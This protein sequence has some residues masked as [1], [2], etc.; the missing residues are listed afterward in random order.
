MLVICVAE[1][2]NHRTIDLDERGRELARFQSFINPRGPIP[3]EARAVHRISKEGCRVA[4]S[5]FEAVLHILN[6]NDLPDRPHGRIAKARAGKP[7]PSLTFGQ[8]TTIKAPLVG[9]LSRL[10]MT[11]I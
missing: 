5:W 7:R 10:A 3:P 9:T 4:R 8:L 6:R 1:H 11:S 2:D